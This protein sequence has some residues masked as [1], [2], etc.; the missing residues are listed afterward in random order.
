MFVV[1]DVTNC[2]EQNNDREQ[3]NYKNNNCEK[4]GSVIC[5]LV[6][7]HSFLK[8]IDAIKS[9]RM[10]VSLVDYLLIIVSKMLSKL[11]ITMDSINLIELGS[12]NNTEES[13]QKTFDPHL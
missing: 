13:L 6:S 11:R 3:R 7:F 10:G 2:D 12:C 5:D 1:K 8:F 9:I 4:I